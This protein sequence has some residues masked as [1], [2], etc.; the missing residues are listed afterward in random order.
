MSL[1]SR[2]ASV[3]YFISRT[4]YN[5]SYKVPVQCLKLLRVVVTKNHTYGVITCDTGVLFVELHV[6]NYSSRRSYIFVHSRESSLCW[7]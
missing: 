4:T 2:A 7:Q 6:D 3:Y 1:I 5:H